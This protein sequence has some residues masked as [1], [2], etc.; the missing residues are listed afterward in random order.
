MCLEGCK[1]DHRESKFTKGEK[2]MAILTGLAVLSSFFMGL[3]TLRINDQQSKA[4]ANFT[5]QQQISFDK[6][7]AAWQFIIEIT[8]MN[9]ALQGYTADY[10]N[11]YDLGDENGR[12]IDIN[13][14]TPS[15]LRIHDQDGSRFWEVDVK[16]GSFVSYKLIVKPKRENGTITFEC[17]TI[18][19]AWIATWFG[20]YIPNQIENVSVVIDNPIIPSPLYSDHGVYYIHAADISKFNKNLSEDL[21]DF[22]DILMNA[23]T[24]RQ[25]LQNYIDSHPRAQIKG[26]YFDAYMDMRCDIIAAAGKAPIILEELEK[27]E[28]S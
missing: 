9:F 14:H 16:P 10:I 6:H 4:I 5:M 23:E 11:Y 18:T 26:Q 24:D 22:Y 3:Y 15:L 2:V 20:P 13:P 8:R 28:N 1:E 25:Y 21:F 27:E 7:A 12:S 19:P 17:P